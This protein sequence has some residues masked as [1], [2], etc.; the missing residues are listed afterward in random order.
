MVASLRCVRTQFQ[1]YQLAYALEIKSIELHDSIERLSQKIV[2]ITFSRSYLNVRHPRSVHSVSPGRFNQ[3]GNTCQVMIFIVYMFKVLW[4]K[5]ILKSYFETYSQNYF[6][7]TVSYSRFT[8]R[9]EKPIIELPKIVT[10]KVCFEK[11]VNWK[12]SQDSVVRFEGW[13]LN[14]QQYCANQPFIGLD[15]QTFTPAN[16]LLF[17]CFTYFGEVSFCLLFLSF[18]QPHPTPPKGYHI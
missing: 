12:L 6:N 13:P 14:S 11:S 18:P 8:R 1:W 15:R 2:S 3:T 4:S 5:H 17:I 9:S 10:Y 16:I 7:P